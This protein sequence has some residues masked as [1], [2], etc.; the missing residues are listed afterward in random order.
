[1][2]YFSVLTVVVFAMA[3]QGQTTSSSGSVG[4]SGATRTA[5]AQTSDNAG[6]SGAARV[7][8]AATSAPTSV[9][10]AQSTNLSAELTK[11][12]D[13]KNAR[14]GEEVVARTTSTAHLSDGTKVP[15]GT[16]LMG[17]VTEVQ[18]KSAQ[19][20]ASRLAFTFDR[21][22]MHNGSMIPIR[23]VVMSLTPPAVVSASAGSDDSAIA[24]G[25]PVTMNDG[26]RASASGGGLLGGGTL[27]STGNAVGNT[28]GGLTSAT[29]QTLN[30]TAN[31]TRNLGSAAVN[32]VGSTASAAGMR[33]SNLPG[34]T[35]DSETGASESAALNAQGKNISLESGTQMTLRVSTNR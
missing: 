18:S 5:A 29:T 12:V 16:R 23:A 26:G 15:R 4:A 35:F 11:K 20:K 10:V 27:R 8:P 32:T 21:A 1:M 6:T 3:A 28:A 7:S 2:R 17:K 31:S 30:T 24:G 22:V 19:Q 13:T 33:V 14:V 25:G 34:V 9:S